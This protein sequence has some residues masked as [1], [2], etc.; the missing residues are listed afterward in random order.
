MSHSNFFRWTVSLPSRTKRISKHFLGSLAAAAVFVAGSGILFA[1]TVIYETGR[2]GKGRATAIGTVVEFNG[3]QLT[4]RTEAGGEQKIPAARVVEVQAEWLP[5]Q[6]EAEAALAVGDLAKAAD[7]FLQAYR[8]EKRPWV[9]VRALAQYARC[10]RNLGRIEQAGAAV[11]EL[12]RR[13][14]QALYLDVL[15][16]CWLAQQPSPALQAQAAKWLAADQPAA[17]R[18]LG[19]SWLLATEQRGAAM[20]ALKD[21]AT[22]LDP[23]IVALAETQSWRTQL[24]TATKADVERWQRAVAKMPTTLQA[25][26]WFVIGTARARLD[27]HDQAVLA[28]L[29][30]PVLH[31]DDRNLAAAALLFAGRSLVKADQRDEAARLF[32]EI[33]E[34]HAGSSFAAEAT[35][36]LERMQAEK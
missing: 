11:L 34:Q 23:R 5:Q 20:A 35:A 27:E 12:L 13:D 31:G 25:G 21:L 36:E 2:D 33:V 6:Q 28:L 24:V 8:A 19:A 14:P 22:D 1:D 17:A 26:G 32:R 15:P 9:Q 16:L 7:G 30:V 4:L 29:R 18:L 10:Q 3:Q